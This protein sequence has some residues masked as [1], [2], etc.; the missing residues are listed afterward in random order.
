MCEEK[1]IITATP[2]KKGWNSGLSPL[3]AI[4]GGFSSLSPMRVFRS[5][6]ASPKKKNTPPASP[7]RKSKLNN[8]GPFAVDVSTGQPYPSKAEWWETCVKT[9]VTARFLPFQSRP[10]VDVEVAAQSFTDNTS[11]MVYSTDYPI[12][13]AALG[14]ITAPLLFASLPS[15]LLVLI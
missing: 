12:A 2:E 11:N 1:G 8:D 7:S 6:S 9:R 3:N 14:S 13:A 15:S 4:G 10:F 5:G